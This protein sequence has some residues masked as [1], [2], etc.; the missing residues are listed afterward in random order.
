MFSIFDC[1]KM[2]DKQNHICCVLF[3]LDLFEQQTLH[4][5]MSSF[6]S[7]NSDLTLVLI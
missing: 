1:N 3:S 2:L 7:Y 6:S 5:I 4:H